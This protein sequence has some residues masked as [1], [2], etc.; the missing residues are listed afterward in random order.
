VDEEG[1]RTTEECKDGPNKK[2]NDGV[3]SDDIKDKEVEVDNNLECEADKA[4]KAGKCTEA[5]GK[6]KGNDNVI[7][8]FVYTRKPYM[9]YHNDIHNDHAIYALEVLTA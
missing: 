5:S 1:G 8:I 3:E 2:N 6:F 4:D 7:Y 9:I